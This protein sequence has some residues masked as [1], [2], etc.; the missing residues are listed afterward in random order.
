M[1]NWGPMGGRNRR[2]E[3]K[4]RHKSSTPGSAKGGNCVASS[5]D[6]FMAGYSRSYRHP[7][8]QSWCEKKQGI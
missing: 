6:R 3:K 2:K 4:G 1:I 7:E 8:Y 5:L